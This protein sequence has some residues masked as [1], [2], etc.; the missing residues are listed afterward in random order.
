MKTKTRLF[1]LAGALVIS[2]LA[3]CSGGQTYK[4]LSFYDSVSKK[5]VHSCKV[6]DAVTAESVAP[7]HPGYTYKNATW[8]NNHQYSLTTIEDELKANTYSE[9][10]TG[11]DTYLTYTINLNYDTITYTISYIN[12]EGYDTS[13]WLTS[14][15]VLTNIKLPTLPNKTNY[16]FDGWLNQD[17]SKLKSLPYDNPRDLVLS[18]IFTVIDRTITYEN[19]KGLKNNNPTTFNCEGQNITLLPLVSDTRYLFVK[20][21]DS[22][23]NTITYIDA[24]TA[25]NV[26]VYAVT[27]AVNHV[28]KFYDDKGNLLFEKEYNADNID[29][30]QMPNVPA[31]D[32]YTG[33]WVGELKDDQDSTFT[34]KYVAEQYYVL[35]TNLNGA[36]PCIAESETF[37]YLS[38]VTLNAP[39]NIP[40]GYEFDHYE[41]NGE[42]V[43]RISSISSDTT[44]NVVW[45]LIEYTLTFDST[46]LEEKYSPI[47]FTVE[48]EVVLPV[49]VSSLYTFNGWYL[50]DDA[51]CTILANPT[52]FSAGDKTLLPSI[53]GTVSTIRLFDKDGN[54][55]VAIQAKYS[56]PVTLPEPQQYDHLTFVGYRDLNGD[57][58]IIYTSNEI[59]HY[60]RA[61]NLDLAPVYMG[62]T[63]SI[64]VRSNISQYSDFTVELTYPSNYDSIVDQI[65]PSDDYVFMGLYFDAEHTQKIES[66]D[67]VDGDRDIY[68]DFRLVVRINQYADFAQISD[69]PEYCYYLT[70]DINCLGNNLP[71]IENFTG[72]FDG[73]N[74]KIFNFTFNVANTGLTCGLFDT[75]NGTIRN[76]TF[77]GFAASLTYPTADNNT[78]NI[79][80]LSGINNGEISNVAI[81]NMTMS[82]S[83]KSRYSDR[84]NVGGFAGL[85]NGIIKDISIT[86]SSLSHNGQNSVTITATDTPRVSRYLGIG[87]GVNSGSVDGCV[88]D[89]CQNELSTFSYNGT[90]YWPS[91]NSKFFTAFIG[92]IAVND[93]G[94]AKNI[95]VIRDNITTNSVSFSVTIHAGH[96]IGRQINGASA[97][98]ISVNNSTLIAHHSN[99]GDIG[100]VVGRNDAGS[101]I[102]DAYSRN[103]VVTTDSGSSSRNVGGFAGYNA[104]NITSSYA[105]DE[106]SA[107]ESL[108]VG[109]F[110]GQNIASATVY[111]CF[112]YSNISAKGGSIARFIGIN[113]GSV[114]NSYAIKNVTLELNGNSY[115]KDES[116]YVSSVQLF[117]VLNNDLFRQLYWDMEGWIIDLSSFP[118]LEIDFDKEIKKEEVV[119]ASC[120]KSGFTIVYV[121]GSNKYYIKDATPSI[122]HDWLYSHTVEATCQHEGYDVEVCSRC[123]AERRIEETVTPKLEHVVDESKPVQEPTCETAGYFTCSLCEE[124]IAVDATGHH[125]D[126]TLTE[127]IKETTCEEAGEIHYHCTHE[128]CDCDGGIVIEYPGPHTDV[129]GD[130]VC[131]VCGEYTQD[132]ND[133]VQIETVSQFRNINDDLDGKYILKNDLDFTGYA[134]S[135]IGD[136]DHPFTGVLYGNS[137]TIKNISVDDSNIQNVNALFYRN[138]GSIVG[139]NI[140]DISLKI[141]GDRNVNFGG[142]VY[143]NSGVVSKCSIN[144]KVD[145]HAREENITNVL[146][147]AYRQE[148]KIGGL[149]CI[150]NAIGK[151]NNCENKASSLISIT[152]SVLSTANFNI[153]DL[154]NNFKKS[155]VTSDLIIS[156]SPIVCNN[157][158]TIQNV[159]STGSI[160]VNMIEFDF[161]ARLM[162]ELVVTTDIYVASLAARNN[163]IIKNSVG[164]RV[165]TNIDFESLDISEIVSFFTS[166]LKSTHKTTFHGDLTYSYLVAYNGGIISG[167]ELIE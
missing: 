121:E 57:D 122:G 111:K 139:L 87:I 93:S 140:K 80:F 19:T 136:K 101:S 35:F 112:S 126:A 132:I 77:E 20:W 165:S 124:I 156:Y 82:L 105:E 146:I 41:I 147:A 17:G 117:E 160:E 131:D 85:N 137:K 98:H 4:M 154:L 62:N 96:A 66:N 91:S 94:S 56:E 24:N 3:G 119:E 102:A 74:F 59:E 29:E 120:D 129:D 61:E 133:F 27:K 115:D 39:T 162:G 64:N 99:S 55:P 84:F 33:E 138:E 76:V 100:A 158:G 50:K 8:G 155:K 88:A 81:N 48:D 167:C 153:L 21:T 141:D 108:N 103:C 14:Y 118:V 79:G 11:G 51:D 32:H 106:I 70:N 75:N 45:N 123:G 5:S 23:G 97:D 54:N 113:A 164:Q 161:L 31:K 7:Q 47:K 49:S 149:V 114:S 60:D 157:L 145:I 116:A 107:N 1:T 152:N 26:T 90:D 34:A 150:N 71:R 10:T 44:V 63:Y 159:T 28:A 127:V 12:V 52:K 46:Y 69:H 125:Y 6:E 67:I 58:T 143:E 135:P 72:I 104:G 151:V 13:E 68:A 148:S 110:A 36:T 109:G 65:T 166:L 86:N 95:R 134:L 9:V 2:L 53:D 163:G 25:Y 83:L 43:D 37:E 73:M 78:K 16:T 38:N 89:L 40:E 142:I 30:F 128:N 92:F 15:T 42:T 18:P 22:E 130:L 144:G